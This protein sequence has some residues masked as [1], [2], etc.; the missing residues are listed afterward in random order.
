[1]PYEFPKYPGAI[2]TDEDF[3]DQKDN[4][5]WV[6]DWLVNA[7]KEELQACLTELGT[8]PKGAYASVKARIEAIQSPARVRAYLNTITGV[9]S[10]EFVKVPFDAEEYDE[11]GEYDHEV[12]HKY[13]AKETGLYLI[14]SA[15]NFKA[16]DSDIV[17]LL[18]IF[19]NGT[20]INWVTTPTGGQPAITGLIT[21]IV[22]LNQNDYIEIFCYHE[23]GVNKDI[24][25]N[26]YKTWLSIAKLG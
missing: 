23:A 2:F 4:E 7:L 5:N 21:E 15:V 19:K 24:D 13:T 8:N 10:G 11:K 25:K 3:P 17:F 6:Y 22:K 14:T 16:I 18:A 1:M 26:S 20:Q 9:A 12:N